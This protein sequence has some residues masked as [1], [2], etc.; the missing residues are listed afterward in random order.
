MSLCL[1]LAT[2]SSHSLPLASGLPRK[3]G[4]LGLLS[5]WDMTRLVSMLIVFRFLRIIPSVKVS[6]H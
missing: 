4:K 5:L 6:W 2:P 1:C 3:P